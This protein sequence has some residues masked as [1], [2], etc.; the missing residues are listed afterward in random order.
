MLKTRVIVALI[1]LPIL[2]ALILSG[3]WVFAIGVTI[4]LLLAGDEYVRLLRQG[5][6]RPSEVIVLGMIL[7]PLAVTWFEHPSATEPGLLLGLFVTMFRIEWDR[8][9]EKPNAFLDNALAIFGG[10]Y[11]GWFG[12]RLIA[13]RMLDDGA[14]LALFAYGMVIISDSAAYFAGRQWG[15]HKLA[16]HISPKKTWEGYIAGVIAATT[17]GAGIAA[18]GGG[19]LAVWEG[20]ALGLLIGTFG[21]VG[22]L[23]ISAIKRQVGAK[24]SSTLIPGHGGIL[25]RIDSVLI[26][27]AIAYYF[28]IW[29]H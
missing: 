20:A 27:F 14:Y 28:V 29:L 17:I 18:L 23:G 4:A 2:V 15:A 21:T 26:G 1:A 8:Q 16:S 6:Y 25:D 9:H 3:D 24:D 10:I 12:S 11:F 22:D 5:G 7:L 13:L 19:P